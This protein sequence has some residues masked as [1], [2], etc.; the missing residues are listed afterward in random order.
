VIDENLITRS[1]P[2]NISG[3]SNLGSYFNYGFPLVKT[4]STLAFNSSLNFGKNL[5][6][7]NELLNETI[8][9]RY[10][11]GT[12][13]AL[14]P[15]DNFTFYLEG[16]WTISNTR[17]S[18]NKQLDQRFFNSSYSAEM[19]LKFPGD[20][21]LSSRFNLNTFR[22]SRLNFNPIQP[23]LNLSVYKIMLKSKKGEIRLSAFDVFNQNQGISQSAFQNFVTTSRVS[24][25]A[26]YFMLS[27]TYN[28]RG[29]KGSVRKQGY[30]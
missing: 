7:I 20:V 24:T 15:N 10:N 6:F 16:D 30:Y 5:I 22:N 2:E 13:L 3:G 9:N 29:V 18:V 28:M 1:R 27:F 14:T 21:Y 4:K 17:F 11:F 23:I 19:N 25:L 12:D 26:R 8:S